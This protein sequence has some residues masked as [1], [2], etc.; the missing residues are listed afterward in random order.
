MALLETIF[1]SGVCPEFYPSLFYSYHILQKLV[2]YFLSNSILKYSLFFFF[3]FFLFLFFLIT[4]LRSIIVCRIQRVFSS[5]FE[6]FAHSRIYFRCLSLPDCSVCLPTFGCFQFYIGFHRTKSNYGRRPSLSHC[7]QSSYYSPTSRIEIILA[8]CGRNRL[9]HK[10]NWILYTIIKVSLENTSSHFLF[11]AKIFYVADHDQ[12]SF[13]LKLANP[14][15]SSFFFYRRLKFFHFSFS[16][17][18][19]LF[20]FHYI[21]DFNTI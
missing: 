2:Y 12:F 21:N 11:Q 15:F 18:F 9:K 6:A 19:R 8:V 16:F 1:W 7:F 5:I 20:P 4:L 17:A 14:I 13:C 10:S 3:L